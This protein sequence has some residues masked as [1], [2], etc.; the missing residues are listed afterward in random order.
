[1][2]CRA[3]LFCDMQVSP[4]W[5]SLVMDPASG[6]SGSNATPSRTNRLMTNPSATSSTSS[7]TTRP[8]LPSSSTA[9]T[10]AAAAVAVA[11][12]SLTAAGTARSAYV[13][14]AASSTLSSPDEASSLE[15]ELKPDRDGSAASGT[16]RTAPPATG[17]RHP[18]PSSPPS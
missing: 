4:G 6:F 8:V 7:P 2:F 9:A 3:L 5:E 10:A 12:P 13:A 15:A 1:M 18:R 17:A 16:A 11:G 14:S